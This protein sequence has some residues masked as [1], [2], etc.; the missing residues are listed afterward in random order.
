MTHRS[1]SLLYAVPGRPVLKNEGPSTIQKTQLARI[2]GKSASSD[3]ILLCTGKAY[4]SE[5]TI[6]FRTN[7]AYLLL[8]SFQQRGRDTK[9]IPNFYDVNTVEE[10]RA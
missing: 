10:E 7:K 9:T 1:Y 6:P 4:E 5:G 3:F 8:L 2:M